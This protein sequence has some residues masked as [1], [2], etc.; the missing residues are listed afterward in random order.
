MLSPASDP[1]TIRAM[2]RTILIY[3]VTLAAAALALEWLEYRY[4]TRLFAAEIYIALIAVLFTALGAWAGHKLTRK[5][6]P[7]VFETNHAAVR[8]L[9]ITARE[10]ETLALLADGLA[11]KEIARTLG[12][13]PNT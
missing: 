4:I 3:G 7:P 6:P 12:I 13:S 11:N 8:A 10:L 9:A 1:V 5:A 2:T